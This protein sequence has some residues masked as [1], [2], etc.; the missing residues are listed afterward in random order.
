LVML[1]GLEQVKKTP[2]VNIHSQINL[3]VIEEGF[4]KLN[5]KA[6]V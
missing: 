6:Q 4:N 2:L 1:K 3:I 5:V